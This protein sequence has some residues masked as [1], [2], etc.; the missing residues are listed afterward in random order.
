MLGPQGHFNKEC[1]PRE[2]RELCHNSF[3]CNQ[4]RAHAIN[5]SPGGMCFRFACRAEPGEVVT[6]H[7][8]PTVQVKA[9]I[10]WTRRLDKCTEVG[11]QFLD[12]KD[13]IDAWIAA[14]GERVQEEREEKVLALPAPGQ[15]FRPNPT[16]QASNTN[17][18]P[19]MR[20]GKSWRAAYSLM[21]GGHN[22][23]S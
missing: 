5:L 17:A 7:Q 3:W 9:R 15:T 4:D 18:S 21:G 20:I 16:Y 8:G 22:S 6:L 11:V 1:K 13:K 14:Q 2:L 19:P 12:D 23:N 10:A